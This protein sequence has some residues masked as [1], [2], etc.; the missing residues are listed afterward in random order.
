MASITIW[1]SFS[2]Y[3]Q[4]SIDTRTYK[5]FNLNG[6]KYNSLKEITTPQTKIEHV[7][8]SFYK[9]YYQHLLEK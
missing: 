6:K 7:L 4:A 3:Q 5:H 9:Y 2:I 1:C 8:C